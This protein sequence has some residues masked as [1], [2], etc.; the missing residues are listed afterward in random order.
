M[1]VVILVGI[2][3]SVQYRDPAETYTLADETASFMK[4]ECQKY[5]D[6]VRGNPADRSDGTLSLSAAFGVCAI[7][8]EG[9][10]F[11]QAFE[12]ADKEMYRDKKASRAQR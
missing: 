2:G 1:S 9:M 7:E 5:D 3:F 6:Y 12:V 8:G 4:V 11:D 10:S